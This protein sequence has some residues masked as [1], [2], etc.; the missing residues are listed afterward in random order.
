MRKRVTV[1]SGNVSVKI[2]QK[3]HE[4]MT[5]E[6][7]KPAI[8]SLGIT[9]RSAFAE[10]AISDYLVKMWLYQSKFFESRFEPIHFED[11]NITIRDYYRVGDFNLSIGSNKSNEA[12]IHCLQ[13]DSDSCEHVGYAFSLPDVLE[14][15]AKKGIRVRKS[16]EQLE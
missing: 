1:R 16:R 7:N 9:S 11:N 13:D 12:I 3:M 6:V 15:F 14:A 5:K 4:Q 8:Q 10:R 2:P